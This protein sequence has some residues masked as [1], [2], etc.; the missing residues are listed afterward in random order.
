MPCFTFIAVHRRL[1]EPFREIGLAIRSEERRLQ[2]KA[3]FFPCSICFH[4]HFHDALIM[5]RYRR[6]C[7][8]KAKHIH[9]MIIRITFICRYILRLADCL[10]LTLQAIFNLLDLLGVADSSVSK[11]VID[12]LSLFVFDSLIPVAFDKRLPGIILCL[13]RL[14]APHLVVVGVLNRHNLQLH[15]DELHIVLVMAECCITQAT[16][17]S[18]QFT[19]ILLQSLC[20]CSKLFY[21]LALPGHLVYRLNDAFF[22]SIILTFG[23]NL[24]SQVTLLF[25]NA[26]KRFQLHRR[27][28][29]TVFALL[30][31]FF[32]AF[33]EI[34]SIYAAVI[35]PLL[36]L[37][38]M[39]FYCSIQAA[40]ILFK[41]INVIFHVHAQC[42]ADSRRAHIRVILDM[43][44]NNKYRFC[45]QLLSVFRFFTL[46]QFLFLLSVIFL[47]VLQ[48]YLEHLFL[49]ISL[50]ALYHAAIDV[51]RASFQ[52]IH[53]AAFGKIIHAFFPHSN[54]DFIFTGNHAVH[55]C[56]NLFGRSTA[57]L[58]ERTIDFS[59]PLLEAPEDTARCFCRRVTAL[60]II[61]KATGKA[62]L[63]PEPLHLFQGHCLAFNFNGALGNCN[64]HLLVELFKF[65]L[66]SSAFVLFGNLRII[67]RC[68]LV[69]SGHVIQQLLR[70]IR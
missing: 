59:Q 61:F 69:N 5:R 2:H 11:H 57:N 46:K 38:H 19:L 67:P 52:I 27:S 6:V 24:S 53:T 34:L 13:R 14:S 7:V 21:L 33:A 48:C 41:L 47:N 12:Q 55:N 35:Y 66:H 26:L 62:F 42:F 45:G 54:V 22:C 51:L 9:K 20:F 3:A 17:I 63:H 29:L 8:R 44:L 25:G 32:R 60:Q 39:S 49:S 23:L 10:L 18:K 64:F 70:S 58:A 36:K 50:G 65:T 15:L 40:A 28:Q 31:D 68:P 56:F 16:H 43:L 4:Q 37:F 1:Q 30:H